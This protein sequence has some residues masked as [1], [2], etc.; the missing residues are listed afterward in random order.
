MRLL[1]LLLLT[2]LP[3]LSLYAN[4]DMSGCYPANTPCP[5]Q[6]CLKLRVDYINESQQPQFEKIILSEDIV[7]DLGGLAGL[8]NMKANRHFI[9]SIQNH[10]ST[11][12]LFDTKMILKATAL[13]RMKIELKEANIPTHNCKISL[14]PKDLKGSHTYDIHL[15]HYNDGLYCEVN[16]IK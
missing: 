15:R 14:I 5:F 10:E 7:I 12:C 16:L 11:D 8:V 1:L 9:A 2:T 3:H 13:S 4:N 6:D